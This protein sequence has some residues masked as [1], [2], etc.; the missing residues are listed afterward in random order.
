MQTVAVPQSLPL[1]SS[2]LAAACCPVCLGTF[3][4]KLPSVTPECGHRSHTGCL[5][6][7]IITCTKPECPVCRVELTGEVIN[8]EEI[9]PLVVA[10]ALPLNLYDFSTALFQAGRTYDVR[11]ADAVL[12]M[13]QL[14]LAELTVCQTV[15]DRVLLRARLRMTIMSWREYNQFRNFIDVI[16]YHEAVDDSWY[17]TAPAFFRTWRT[18]QREQCELA[19]SGAFMNPVGLKASLLQAS[20]S[21]PAYLRTV[22]MLNR[23]GT[24]EVLHK[25]AC[26]VLDLVLEKRLLCQTDLRDYE[27]FRGLIDIYLC[28]RIGTEATLGKVV[29]LSALRNDFVYA[30]MLKDDFGVSLHGPLLFQKLG[31][32]ADAMNDDTIKK[33]L[34]LSGAGQSQLL[35]WILQRALTS[36][37][38][39]P[40]L[41]TSVTLYKLPKVI[42]VLTRYGTLGPSLVNEAVRICF[43]GDNIEV[44]KVLKL[45]HGAAVDTEIFMDALQKA[46][47]TRDHKKMDLYLI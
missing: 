9:N 35:N 13:A 44:A 31:R 39:H 5:D 14:S 8:D 43:L 30:Q 20:V 37:N 6:R 28:R 7:W 47:H 25:V 45:H 23:I 17:E 32:A 22:H 3:D 42:A 27:F 41:I 11:R 34:A 16:M 19:D 46:A 40:Q 12:T 4:T 29:A 10:D 33:L 36:V 18:F 2:S 24:D 15:V 1:V 21:P 26:E 38:A